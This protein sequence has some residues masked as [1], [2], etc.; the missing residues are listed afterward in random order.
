MALPKK[1]AVSGNKEGEK[2]SEKIFTIIGEE[3]KKY[4]ELSDLE[5]LE[6]LE[7]ALQAQRM[8]EMERC[9]YLTEMTGK[10]RR[11]LHYI[12]G[13]ADV[14][15]DNMND[16]V[17]LRECLDIIT[18]SGNEMAKYLLQFKRKM[19]EDDFSLKGRQEKKRWDEILKNIAHAIK[20]VLITKHLTLTLDY[21][22]VYHMEVVIEYYHIYLILWNLIENAAQFSNEAGEIYVRIREGECEKKDYGL[23]EIRVQDTGIGISEEFQEKIFDFHTQAERRE[24]MDEIGK[25]IGLGVVKRTVEWLEGTI[26]VE[27]ILGNGSTFTVTL[28]LRI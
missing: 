14:A 4:E 1:T 2:M 5:K 3:E 25:G 19:R 22:D 26:A 24:K 23:F 27:S 13:Y 11:E 28:P 8:M 18:T 6:R 20:P 9:V 21:S 12:L 7:E 15:A 16:H 10:M 17:N